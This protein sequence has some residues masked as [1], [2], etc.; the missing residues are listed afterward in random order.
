VCVRVRECVCARESVCMCVCA[1]VCIYV[2]LYLKVYVNL[3]RSASR[4]LIKCVCVCVCVRVFCIFVCMRELVALCVELSRQDTMTTDN[5]QRYGVAT[6]IELLK[7]IGLFCRIPSLLY[8][9]C[10]KETYNL[11]EPT[12]RSHPIQ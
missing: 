9:P 3:L 5:D 8:G 7:I 12:N 4:S 1:C 10:A 2:T 11:K 6:M